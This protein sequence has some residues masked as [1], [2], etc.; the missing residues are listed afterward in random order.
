[1]ICFICARR[2]QVQRDGHCPGAIISYFLYFFSLPSAQIVQKYGPNCLLLAMPLFLQF[3]F[4]AFPLALFAISV[5]PGSLPA[6]GQKPARLMLSLGWKKGSWCGGTDSDISF[7]FSEAA[8]SIPD[9]F[10]GSSNMAQKCSVTHVLAAC[11]FCCLLE[12]PG[13]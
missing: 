11:H 3:P 2:T 9:I 8:G 12:T 10:K 5:A 7:E 4:S 13:Y 6:F 1:M